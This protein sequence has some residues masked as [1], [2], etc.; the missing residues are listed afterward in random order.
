MKHKPDVLEVR[1]QP[2]EGVLADLLNLVEPTHG[3]P[4]PAVLRASTCFPRRRPRRREND[5]ELLGV[6]HALDFG[7]A[8]EGVARGVHAN[9]FPRP[10]GSGPI[11]RS[12]AWRQHV[13]V[14]EEKAR[15]DE[16]PP[17]RQ[18]LLVP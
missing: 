10:R 13:A 6:G 14:L 1:L 11:H 15:D 8:A 18:H 5:C 4:V 7:E 12:A 17:H 2:A 16:E 9:A 3:Q